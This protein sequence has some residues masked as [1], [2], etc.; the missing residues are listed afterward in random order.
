MHPPLKEKMIYIKKISYT[1]FVAPS[2]T[3]SRVEDLKTY[4]PNFG[5]PHN[6]CSTYYSLL[7]W[8]S[9]PIQ[10]NPLSWNYHVCFHVS[11]N[12]SYSML[13]SH[14]STPLHFP[15]YV[16]GWSSL[17]FLNMSIKCYDKHPLCSFKWKL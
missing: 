2:I 1:F 8:T 12:I 7:F 4:Y 9:Y 11:Q 5:H 15:L 13:V 10:I 16:I 17:L 14:T 6:C 3:V